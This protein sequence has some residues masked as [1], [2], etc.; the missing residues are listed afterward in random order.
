MGGLWEKVNLK[1]SATE[2]RNREVLEPLEDGL[3]QT[4]AELGLRPSELG[5]LTDWCL[6][7]A[8]QSKSGLWQGEEQRGVCAK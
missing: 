4:L 8:R 1:S 2:A 5:D 6:I 7:H 3:L